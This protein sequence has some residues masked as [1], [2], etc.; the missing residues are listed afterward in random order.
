MLHDGGRGASFSVGEAGS[1]GRALGNGVSRGEHSTTV[2]PSS[3][4]TAPRWCHSSPE[5]HWQG[6]IQ[7]FSAC[8]NTS[9]QNEWIDWTSLQNLF[10]TQYNAVTLDMPQS[11]RAALQVPGSTNKFRLAVN[12]AP[13]FFRSFVLCRPRS[14]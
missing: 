4:Y 1:A 11:I 9:V 5:S 8:D 2:L 3:V 7:A 13:H 12:T 14:F 10:S 6:D